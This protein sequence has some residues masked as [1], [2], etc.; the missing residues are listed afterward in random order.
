MLSSLSSTIKTVFIMPPLQS[1]PGRTGLAGAHG[2]GGLFH[3]DATMRAVDE[4]QTRWKIRKVHHIMRA[5]RSIEDAEALALRALGF[6]ASDPARLEVFLA[7]TGLG[8]ANL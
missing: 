3:L 4:T 7:E 1:R 5:D 8:P 2:S 6:L